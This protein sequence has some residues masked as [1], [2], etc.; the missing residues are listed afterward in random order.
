M[1]LIARWLDP[2]HD[3]GLQRPTL[4]VHPREH[5][6]VVGTHG[7]AVYVFDDIAPL[8]GLT[9]RTLQETLR[10]LP[11]RT[12][13]QYR[14]KQTGASRFPGHGEFRGENRP[15]GASI[16]FVVNGEQLPHPDEEVEKARQ[17][18]EDDAKTR[19]PESNH[20]PRSRNLW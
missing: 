10:L 18:L 20:S 2:L 8:R 13:R 12:A 9:P 3:D 14:V 4:E 6:L 1:P 11:I 19:Q 17:E 15:Y 16:S 5:A 7:R